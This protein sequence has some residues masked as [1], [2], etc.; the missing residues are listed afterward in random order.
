MNKEETKVLSIEELVKIQAIEFAE[1]I[2]NKK[3]CVPRLNNG[4]V[5][6]YFPNDDET[7]IIESSTEFLHSL[8]LQ[9]QTLNK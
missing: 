9:S 1:W 6:W 7:E 3:G 4:I 8:Y 5:K 2:A